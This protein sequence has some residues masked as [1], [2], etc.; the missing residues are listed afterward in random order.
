[1]I[2]L[3]KDNIQ[4]TTRDPQGRWVPCDAHWTL[5]TIDPFTRNCECDGP[6]CNPE[7][8]SRFADD[9]DE[10]GKRFYRS[11]WLC[12]DGG[13]TACE[14]CVSLRTDSDSNRY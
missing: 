2:V 3:D 14:A 11:G 8:C 12:L 4:R 7:T 1:M 13:E 10:C 9:C 6:E 5:Y